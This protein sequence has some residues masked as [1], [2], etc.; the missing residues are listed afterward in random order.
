[1]IFL[2][3]L[4]AVSSWW[5]TAIL[6][7]SLCIS[8]IYFSAGEKSYENW[9]SF[10]LHAPAGLLL[11]TGL[12]ANLISATI[13]IAYT[14]LRTLK[15]TP[16]SIKKMDTFIEIPASKFDSINAISE[17]ISTKG[18]PADN[19]DNCANSLRGKFSF[20]PGT[21]MRAGLVI[22]MT[23]IIFSVH[24]RKVDDRIFH[25]GDNGVLLNKKLSLSGINT[26]MPD[27]FLQIGEKGTFRLNNVSAALTLSQKQYTVTGRFPAR[28]NGL[29]YRITNLGFYQSLSVMTS[30]K[31]FIKDIY[32]NV[33]PPGKTDKTA[34]PA[35]NMTLTFSL[36]P[37]KTI[38][39]GLITG[40]SYNLKTPLYNVTLQRNNERDKPENATIK[41]SETSALGET[42]I[43]LGKNSL[44]V[45][46]QSVH[47][48]ALIW[49][50]AGIIITI[51]GII[52]M[53]SR[54]FWYEKQICAILIDDKALIGYREEFFK[55][56]GIQKFHKWE[57]ELSGKYL[58]K[59]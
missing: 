26:D 12:T 32:L 49:I 3:H 22:T 2:K 27:E 35:E 30:K 8:Y 54:F 39:K 4:K 58:L 38:Q 44:F 34:L 15:P 25:E 53:P 57:E 1:M 50:Y 43:A 9:I 56:W 59:N 45:K 42:N 21:V 14:K 10:L 20:L 18:F 41:A 46:I 29:Y 24:L 23:A 52:L 16:E 13:R 36:Q 48:P 5:F 11:Y 28:I 37:E 7:I 17:W 6:L 51:T 47:D 33:L 31:V 19:T 40:K 55:R